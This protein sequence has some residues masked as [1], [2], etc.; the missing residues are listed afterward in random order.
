MTTMAYRHLMRVE[1]Q[2]RAAELA[3]AIYRAERWLA[4]R[5]QQLAGL[6]RR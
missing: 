6:S 4:A 5:E 3:E 1:H 2:L